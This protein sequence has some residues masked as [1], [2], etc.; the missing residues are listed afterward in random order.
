MRE[1]LNYYAD[2]VHHGILSEL[3][4]EAGRYFVVSSHREEM[5]IQ[6]QIWLR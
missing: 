3:A 5:L 4:L 6:K 2:V 1:V